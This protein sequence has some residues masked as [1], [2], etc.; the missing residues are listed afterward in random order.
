MFEDC[1][2]NSSIVRMHCWSFLTVTQIVVV[3]SDLTMLIAGSV[4]INDKG[5]PMHFLHHL[6][7]L[8]V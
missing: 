1:C 6:C 3:D 7:I 8:Y 5:L 2:I 4:I